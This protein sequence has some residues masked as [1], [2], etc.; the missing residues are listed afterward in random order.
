MEKKE[1]Y[2]KDSFFTN[3]PSYIYAENVRW[4]ALAPGHFSNAGTMFQLALL[5]TTGSPIIPLAW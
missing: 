4:I 5:Q 3:F 1:I 2:F